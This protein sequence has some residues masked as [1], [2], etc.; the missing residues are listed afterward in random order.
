MLKI[1]DKNFMRFKIRLKQKYLK[2]IYNKEKSIY[3]ASKTV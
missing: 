1:S 2:E 3:H